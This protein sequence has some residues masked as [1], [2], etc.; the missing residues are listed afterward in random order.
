MPLID[1]PPDALAK[2]YAGSLFE[3]A[4]SE[5]GRARLEELSGEL[6][7]L[8]ELTRAEPQLS[9]FFA[10][11]ILPAKAR[12]GSIEAIF[13]GRLSDVLVNF[14]LVLN[15]KE[16]LNQFLPIAAAYD[17]MVQEKFGRIEIDVYTRY[18]LQADQLEHIR[19]RLQNLMQREPVVHAY[20]NESMIGGV[21]LQVGD[22][23]IDASLSTRLRKM[24]DQL[25]HEGGSRMRS[26]FEDVFLDESE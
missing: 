1:S 4:E 14:L 25:I 11:Q 3:L 2:V 13:R 8:V 15:R 7:E 17:Q 23:L 5:G 21:M 18:S 12:G 10:S 26:K 6:D 22:K 19:K 9:E 24:R 16:R 20:T